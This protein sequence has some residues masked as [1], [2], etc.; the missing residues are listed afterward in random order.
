MLVAPRPNFQG[1]KS[2]RFETMVFQKLRYSFTT[3]ESGLDL[4]IQQLWFY[5]LH[6]PLPGLLNTIVLEYFD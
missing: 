6:N 1:A 2:T 3:K 4:F 5:E